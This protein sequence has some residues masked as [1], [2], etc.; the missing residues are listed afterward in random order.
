MY[1]VDLI[2]MNVFIFYLKKSIYLHNNNNDD[3]LPPNI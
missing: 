3:I 1:D 2:F